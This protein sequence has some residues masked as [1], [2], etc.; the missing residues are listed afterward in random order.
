MRPDADALAKVRERDNDCCAWCG[1]PIWGER[2]R[3]WSLHHRRPAGMGGDKKPE[4]HS[5]A[6][7]VLLHGSGT[8]LCHGRVERHRTDAMARGY[9]ISRHGG[10]PPSSFCIEHAVHA[11]CYLLDDGSIRSVESWTE[12]PVFDVDA[13]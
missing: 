7:L 12:A 9:L 3:D 2:G 6:N 8:T 10:Q 5:P 11:L 1:K 4:T 13:S